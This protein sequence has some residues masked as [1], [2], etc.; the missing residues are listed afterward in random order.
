MNKIIA[1]FSGILNI[2]DLNGFLGKY[3]IGPNQEKN[4]NSDNKKAYYYSGNYR[5]F[6][7]EIDATWWDRSKT[8]QIRPDGNMIK[9]LI[10]DSDGK[11]IHSSSVSYHED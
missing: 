6:K 5:E 7:I 10:L 11:I 1:D 9:L 8:H 2:T 4:D 3:R